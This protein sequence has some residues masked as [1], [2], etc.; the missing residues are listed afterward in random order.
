MSRQSVAKAH[1][2]IQ[3]LSWE[4]LYHEP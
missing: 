4:P 2:K 1:E 3:E